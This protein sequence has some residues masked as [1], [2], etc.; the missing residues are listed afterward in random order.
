MNF[1]EQQEVDYILST[2][3][4]AVV[5]PKIHSYDH[6]KKLSQYNYI[7]IPVIFNG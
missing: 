6:I 2:K 4:N 3:G 1:H 7:K 5:R